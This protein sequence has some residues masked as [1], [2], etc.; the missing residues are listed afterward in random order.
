MERRITREFKL[1]A[2]PP[3]QGFRRLLHPTARSRALYDRLSKS[4][5]VRR[6][7]WISLSGCQRNRMQAILIYV[8]ESMRHR[9]YPPT[10]RERS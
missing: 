4:D 3:D 10:F 9:N 8:N 1:E 6:E 5:G 7:G 2:V